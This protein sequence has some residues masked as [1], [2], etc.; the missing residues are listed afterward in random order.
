[1]LKFIYSFIKK[2]N[3]EYEYELNK[4]IIHFILIFTLRNNLI[5][6]YR[7]IYNIYKN[8]LEKDS[9]FY[10]LEGFYYYLN[11][12][13]TNDV[14][15]KKQFKALLIKYFELYLNTYCDGTFKSSQEEITLIDS[16]LKQ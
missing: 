15:E 10:K 6:N 7:E 16:L 8:Y 11:Y 3:Y 12:S 9:S 1:M 4:E 14:N 5:T 13:N 2:V